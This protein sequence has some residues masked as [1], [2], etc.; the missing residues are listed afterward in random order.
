MAG[1]VPVCVFAIGDARSAAGDVLADPTLRVHGRLGAVSEAAYVVRP[2]GYLGSRSEPPDPAQL[3]AHLRM[4][5][6]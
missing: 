6:C 2:D 3:G 1:R 4:F 5:A